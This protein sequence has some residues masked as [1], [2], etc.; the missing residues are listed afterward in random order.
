MRHADMR[1][2]TR[3]MRSVRDMRDVTTANARTG[4]ACARRR[5]RLG[6]RRPPPA[7]RRPPRAGAQPRGA[8]GARKKAPHRGASRTR[9]G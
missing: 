8:G 4:R 3:D 7:A 5:S 1:R 2:A 9:R 6:L